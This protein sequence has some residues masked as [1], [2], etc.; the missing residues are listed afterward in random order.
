ML[1]SQVTKKVIPAAQAAGASS[2]MARSIAAAIPQGAA[3]L[4]AIT[5]STTIIGAASSAYTESLIVSVRTVALS[6]LAFGGVGIIACLCLEDIGHKMN[7]KIEVY[8]E[9]DYQADKN[10]FH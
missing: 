5:N 3:A 9:N 8:L 10:Q 2:S 7:G 1:S 4:S 6:S